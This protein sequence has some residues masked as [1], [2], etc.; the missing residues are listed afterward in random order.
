MGIFYNTC[1][2]VFVANGSFLFGYDAGVMTVVIQSKHFLH[3]FDTKTA[4]N[5]IGAINATF[6]GG[7]V[8]GSLMGGFTMDSLGRKKTILIG[9]IINLIGAVLQTA[10]QHLGMVL[11]GRI[12]AGWAVGLLSMSV[13]VYQS[14]CAHPKKRGF[15]VGIA[16]QMIGVGF[17][18]STWVGYGSSKVPDTN[19][20]SWRF[21]LAF[22]CVP[23]LFIICGIWF[24]P[25][26]P[27]YLV[28]TDRA[29]EALRV[30]HKLHYDGTNE[31]WINQ[32][33]SEIKLT[34]EA[35]KAIT[36]PGWAVMFKVKSW[37]TRLLHAT[38][39]QL[40][41]QMTGINVIGYYQTIMYK[42][43]GIEDDRALLVTGI[44]N[45]V[46]P[47]F[48]LF[49]ILFLVDRVGR[50]KPLIFGTIAITIALICEAA[51]GS[52]VEA[53]TGSR[54]NALSSAGVFFLFLVTCIF[55][56]S[57]GPISWIY[58]SEIMPLS[59]RG[60]G[61]A[62]A[63]GIGNWLVGTVWSQVSPVGL[64]ETQWR[65]YF[66][67]V[68][69]NLVVTLPVIFFFY[70]ETKQLSLEE[71]DLLFGE[72]A[73][74]T[75]PDD[76]DDKQREI[77]M[78]RIENA[79]KILAKDRHDDR[80]MFL[81]SER[82]TAID[83]PAFRISF[84]HFASSFDSK[85]QRIRPSYRAQEP[86]ETMACTSRLTDQSPLLK[87]PP[88]LRCQISEYVIGSRVVY[89]QMSWVG[90]FSPAGYSYRCFDDLQ[91]L[92][93]CS[94]RDLDLKA[95]PFGKD[96]AVLS[97]VCRQMR[98]DTATLP[99]K[100]WVWAFED[101]FTLDQFVTVKGL[102]CIPVHHKNAIRRVA[103]PP[104]GHHQSHEKV[105]QG[106]QEL[107]LIGSAVS[108]AGNDQPDAASLT[109]RRNIIRLRRDTSTGTWSRSD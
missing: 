96:V 75:L 5:T 45:I 36:A 106:L 51:V 84:A 91:P 21:P 56:V 50:R 82:V 61:S 77:E 48:N 80:S 101:A 17:I 72:R 60:R 85:Y 44:Y 43:L 9:A 1:L 109:P 70:K 28:E 94:T 10:A 31:D 103:V 108:S 81:L 8:F 67:F 63:T 83:N 11:A 73:L 88:E 59:I 90:I 79:K 65:F 95:V 100:L 102:G 41:G 12:M 54:R 104:P 105:L 78:E 7:A 64:G 71:I 37:R 58:A 6:S 13:P 27:R 99:F 3:Y 98:Q 32:E 97:C 62:F 33:F 26:S 68:A 93:I 22:Q 49:F 19:S 69:W 107:L 52:Q 86:S 29:D 57:F 35:E 89:V 46:G 42:N 66:I 34:I 14:E 74:G 25:E 53:A 30:L 47:L 20:F 76:L 39:I 15:I 55:S 38:S 23:C 87:L 40:F 18:V 4:S 24:F 2:A 92:L 16:Q